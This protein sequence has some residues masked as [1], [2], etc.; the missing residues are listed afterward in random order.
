VGEPLVIQDRYEVIRRLAI[1]G[2]G[3]IFLARQRTPAGLGGRAHKSFSRLAILKTLRPELAEQ[4]EALDQFLDEARVAS[5]LSHPNIVAIYE[6]GVHNGV[7][8]IAMEYIGGIDLAALLRAASL[9]GRSFPPR[10]AAAVI[11]DASSGLD[12]AHHARDDAG[13]LLRVVHRDVS[14]Q[15]VMLRSDGLVK[16]VDFG[17]VSASNQ[18]HETQGDKLKGKIRYMA[19]EQ[20]LGEDLDGRCDQFSLGIVLWELLTGRPL[21]A[22]NNPIDVF[23][24]IL[25]GGVPAAASVNPEVP[26]ALDAIIA[27]MLARK[28]EDRYARCGEVAEALRNWLDATGGSA[29]AEVQAF[30]QEMA[31]ATI[32][33]RVRD[34]TPKPVSIHGIGSV[35]SVPDARPIEPEPSLDTSAPTRVVSLGRKDDD[36]TTM[37]PPPNDDVH[38][39]PAEPSDAGVLLDAVE[40]SGVI[41][42]DRRFVTVLVGLLPGWSQLAHQIANVPMGAFGVSRLKNLLFRQLQSTA[43]AQRGTVV[44]KGPDS[45]VIAFGTEDEPAP[46]DAAHALQCAFAVRKLLADLAKTPGQQLSAHMGISAGLALASRPDD[47]PVQLAG[48]VVERAERLAATARTLHKSVLVSASVGEIART[49]PHGTELRL[50]EVAVSI[51]GEGT[52]EALPA[53]EDDG[54][55]RPALRPKRIL[56]ADDA[57]VFRRIEEEILRPFGYQFLHAKDGAQAVKLAMEEAPDLILLDV[58]MPIMDGIQVLSLLKRTPGTEK[59]PVVVVTTIGRA[60]DEDLVRRGGADA[61]LTKPV[62]PALLIQTTRSLLNR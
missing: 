1:G 17:V 62:K 15:N 32:A 47:G 11:R 7:H 55:A 10:V 9:K 57:E 6:V 18:M 37:T 61:F 26:A 22:G 12:H 4:G 3:E 5:L 38:S 48:N 31:G 21:F 51:G 19:P 60:H 8:F 35:G 25:A 24:R 14:P 40:G 58:Q 23:Q 28:R 29:E 27:R 43:A 56:I 36:P 44:R 46:E 54:A 34:L 39:E 42:G 59:I 50:E 33:D 41:H 49:P 16:I 53:S 13:Q 2:M 20:L 52:F 45:F 30:V